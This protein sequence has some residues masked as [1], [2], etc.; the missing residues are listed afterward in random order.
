VVGNYLNVWTPPTALAAADFNPAESW[1]SVFWNTRYLMKCIPKALKAHALP[2]VAK[3]QGLVAAAGAGATLS[4]QPRA[5]KTLPYLQ[6]VLI[7]D[8]LVLKDINPNDKLVL[9][10]MAHQDFRYCQIRRPY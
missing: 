8:A 4:A 1:G 10:L 5:S 9:H 6:D 3:F 2:F 7:Q